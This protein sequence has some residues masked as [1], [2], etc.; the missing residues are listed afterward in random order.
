MY[1]IKKGGECMDKGRI[2][3]LERFPEDLYRRLKVYAAMND[4][5]MK[6]IIIKA[7]EEYLD[8]HEKKGA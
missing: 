6:G 1:P 5:T 3:R 2:I 4:L 7:V 8:R